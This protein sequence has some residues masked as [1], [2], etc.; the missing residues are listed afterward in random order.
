MAPQMQSL[1]TESLRVLALD[2]R[3]RC[4]QVHE[5]THGSSNQTIALIRDVLRPVILNQSPSFAI[6][7]NHPSGDP[8]PSQADI[9]FTHELFEAAELMQ[10]TLIDHLIIGHP[11]SN[12]EPYYSFL[13][14]E[15]LA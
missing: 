15:K 13:E 10:L 4:Q 11:S 14:N 12:G 8:S 1:K 3:L 7:H 9:R 2:S 6:V 5:V